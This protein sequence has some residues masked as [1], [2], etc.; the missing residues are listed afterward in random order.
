MSGRRLFLILAILIS[1]VFG[2]DF[3]AYQKLVDEGKLEEVQKA[4]P[5]LI[6]KYPGHPFLL[7]LQASI[8][9]DGDEALAEFRA[10]VKDHPQT[11]AAEL[12]LMKIGEYLYAQGLYSQASD[13]LKIIPL[14]YPGSKNI[15]RAVSL[16][17]KSF[18]ATGEADSSE[19]YLKLFTK[20]YPE[21]NFTD[22]DYYTDLIMPKPA[23]I[24]NEP[25]IEP[26]PA[27]LGEKPWVV[28]VGAFGDKKNAE[29]IMNRL[30]AT[31]YTIELIENSGDLG[32]N[33]VQIVR[34]ATIEEAIIV[35]EEIN[36]NYGL[37][38]RILERN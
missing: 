2:Q 12:A 14:Y 30:K 22:Y 4:L 36:D 15:E 21:L 17:K 29:T 5:D 28:Q 37:E 18:L 35:G 9:L 11:E 20:K 25:E 8:N 26:E 1:S 16:M 33:L 10:I 6:A 27:Q 32:L 38:F 34:F 13:Q 3:S 19:F 31:G 7:Y 23:V 24:V